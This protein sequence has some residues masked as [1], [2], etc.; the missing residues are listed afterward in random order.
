MS[1]DILHK[2][3]YF[4]HVL[5]MLSEVLLWTQNRSGYYGAMGACKGG[6]GKRWMSSLFSIKHKQDVKIPF[7]VRVQAFAVADSFVLA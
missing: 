4:F 5:V 1:S 7:R 6:G 2:G 3:S